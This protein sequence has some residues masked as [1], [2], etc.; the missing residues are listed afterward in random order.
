MKEIQ[1]ELTKRSKENAFSDAK[2]WP[3][4]HPLIIAIKNLKPNTE[5][6]VVTSP[7]SQS[8]LVCLS[9]ALREYL[10]KN[11]KAVTKSPRTEYGEANNDRKIRNHRKKPRAIWVETI[12]N[13][14]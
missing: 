2:T 13:C 6:C 3:D 1:F 10:P 11:L 8:D 14:E 9:R 7:I 12:N 4:D 5:D